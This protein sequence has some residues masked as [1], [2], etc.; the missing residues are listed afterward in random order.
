MNIHQKLS[1]MQRQYLMAVLLLGIGAFAVA[2]VFHGRHGIPDFVILAAGL[3]L[4]VLSLKLLRQEQGAEERLQQALDA[5]S[6][7]VMV[8]DEKHDIVY[9]NR[10]GRELMLAVQDDLRKWMPDFDATRLIG[11]SI[12]RFH[13]NHAHQHAILDNLTGTYTSD[14]RIGPRRMKLTANPVFDA[15][16]RRVGTVVEW[17]D[18]T[19]ELELEEEAARRAEAERAVSMENSRIRQ[20]L[21]A[22]TASVMV[23]DENHDII[24][25]N[26]AAAEL[27]AANEADF[28][29][30]LPDFDASKLVGSN[31]DL[32][33]RNA[34]HQRRILDNLTTTFQSQFTIGSRTMR[35]I[36][37]PIVAPDG[38]RIGTVVQWVDRTQE[39][40]VENE[41]QEIVARALAG[42]LDRRIRLEDK[43]G[44]LKKLSAGINDLLDNISAV[45]R[46]VQALVS[47]VN[48]G[49]LD[50]RISVEGR[51]G[52]SAGL[53]SVVNGLTDT[54]AQVV[55]EVQGL[56][57][58]V[59]EGHLDRRID[60]QGKSGLMKRMAAGINQLAA[61]M[62]GMVQQVKSAAGEVSRVADEIT[63]GNMTLAQR[64]EEQAS[65]L[66]ETASSMEEM[67]ST[68]KQN[69]DNAG[70]A[71]QLA[72]EA[73]SQAE[74]GG[75]VVAQAV[76]AMEEINSASRRIADI[77]GVIDEI[78][79]QTNLLALNAAVE[80]ARAGEQGRGFAVVAAEVRN[81]AGRSATA[82]KEI[83]TLIQDSVQKVHDGST[84]VARS[85]ETLEQIVAAVKRVA[86]IVAEITAASQ[87]QS[88]GIDQVNK[89]VLQLDELT[90]QNAALVEQASAASQAMADQARGLN[91]LIQRYRVGGGTAVAQAAPAPGQGP[92]SGAPGGIERRG[93]GRPWS[94]KALSGLRERAAAR[95]GDRTTAIASAAA[96][97]DQVWK[98]F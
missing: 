43:D 62:A 64:M 48:D 5:V 18:R 27:M 82:A 74:R 13:R 32:F 31:I 8:A 49:N 90:Q 54:M 7:N 69:A 91:T 89:A 21:D 9:M 79:F 44:F 75:V 65:S 93:P 56:V 29:S 39:V 84:L 47:A 12:D 68:V 58:A 20:A 78:A 60:A 2:P 70:Q 51:S 16:G 57:D 24:Y 81:L 33:H 14:I 46:E 80:A 63:Q 88:A 35:F 37:N 38:R 26:R 52:L 6:V 30:S 10:T 95:P 66:E 1:P 59:N 25:M 61:N 11:S 42:D 41:V 17:R 28:R 15:R 71:N 97:G 92:Q 96:S 55:E 98:E 87:E 4:A 67:T 40:A 77:I 45:G 72:V 3:G 76:Q 94:G 50:R 22:T 23:A 85:G 19:R 73:R 53:V 86:D 34:A 36:A 83:K